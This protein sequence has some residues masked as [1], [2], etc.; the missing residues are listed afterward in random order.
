[1]KRRTTA[2]LLIILI[3]A[4]TLFPSMPVQ[5]ANVYQM[6]LKVTFCQT[7][8]RKELDMVNS[9][10]T[11]SEAWYWN[12][13]NTT[14]TTPTLST[15]NYDYNLEKV[16][17]QRAVEI[18]LNYDHYRADGAKFTK[19]YNDLGYTYMSSG[20]N[21][22]C[23]QFNANQ[24]FNAWKEDDDLYEGQEHRRNMLS[25]TFTDC[26]FACVKYQGKYYW[27][28]EFSKSG[29]TSYVE[30][31]A[32]NSTCIKNAAI[33]EDNIGCVY[34]DTK[35][36]LHGDAYRPNSRD[37]HWQ[38]LGTTYSLSNMD[39]LFEVCDDGSY[40][41]KVV[42]TNPT[43]EIADSS[44]ASISNGSLKANKVGE[45]TLTAN[46]QLGDMVFMT[47]AHVKVV[48]T[49]IEVS[50][51]DIKVAVGTKE[52]IKASLNPY[53]VYLN[54]DVN[55]SVA[56]SSIA[57]VTNNNQDV[58]ITGIKLGTTTLVAET[59]DGVVKNTFP[60]EVYQSVTQV[61][62]A[63][64]NSIELNVD[65]KMQLSAT[66]LPE[67]ASDKEY[68]WTSSDASVAT[69]S[70]NGLITAIGA[71]QVEIRATAK[72]KYNTSTN[73]PYG[74]VVV[75][76]TDIFADPVVAF[77]SR[78]YT[79][80]LS[81]SYDE[82]GLND[83]TSQLKNGTNDGAGIAQGFIESTEFVNRNLSNEQYLDVL[84]HTFFDRDPDEGGYQSWLAQ[85][86]NGTSRRFV[87]A[88]FVN[89]EEFTNL[90][91]KFGITRGT[92]DAGSQQTNAQVRAFVE[93]M[94]V[95]ALGR[96]GEEDGINSWTQRIVS[97]EWQAAEVAKA[98][99]FNSQEYVLKNRTNDEFVEDLYQALFDR[100]SDE[101]GKADWLSKL[102]NGASR[103]DVM[104]GFGGSQ[105][106]ANML[107]GFG[108]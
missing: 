108:L 90:C 45:T 52:T 16:A 72:D 63:G 85:L 103:E 99:F 24:V 60:I 91:N 95:K 21:I 2:I 17:M 55:W 97:G 93:R 14:K 11:G 23:G 74:S 64:N 79:V 96:H 32:D 33:S 105:E 80:A 3:M 35:E 75:N 67:N 26:G 41:E 47:T 100:P 104:N 25:S 31:S 78:M 12:S 106:F 15:L 84:Y 6:P 38:Q 70:E 34:I 7:E 39:I 76:V 94:Y 28:Q 49:K 68:E 73:K 51:P 71:G 13:D 48:D 69:V 9:F 20:E 10:R 65:D 50:K 89:S 61:N 43:W 81:R 57:S 53:D 5:A 98:G 58:Y 86:N 4:L 82:S 42:A 18:A 36:S 30:T 27:V 101:A 40:V 102:A 88:G 87:L 8:A 77:V 22:A 1:M 83:W 56:D 19:T 107:A 66:V 92:L 59:N 44:I 46:C 62:V 29:S 37:K 54:E